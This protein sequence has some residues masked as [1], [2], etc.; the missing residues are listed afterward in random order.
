MTKST[1]PFLDELCRYASEVEAEDAVIVKG[2]KHPFAVQSYLPRF[3][4]VEQNRL[5]SYQ[6]DPALCTQRYFTPRPKTGLQ[7]RECEPSKFKPVSDLFGA[8][9]VC[10]ENR[11]EVFEL[12]N[13]LQGFNIM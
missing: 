5:L 12:V 1:K 13:I 2:H 11:T 10:D 8:L 9:A 6:V 7:A 3:A 4:T